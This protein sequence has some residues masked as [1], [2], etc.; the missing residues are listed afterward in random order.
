MRG[1]KGIEENPFQKNRSGKNKKKF[2]P[3]TKNDLEGLRYSDRI[4]WKIIDEKVACIAKDAV[5]ASNHVSSKEDLCS[6]MHQISR[7]TASIF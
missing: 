4:S 7:E 2:K 6:L 3:I 5:E 1:G